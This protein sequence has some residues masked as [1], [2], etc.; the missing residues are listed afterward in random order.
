M[1]NLWKQPTE[2]PDPLRG[3]LM[4][5]SGQQCRWT[6]YGWSVSAYDV[7]Y[8]E[9][10]WCYWDEFISEWFYREDEINNLNNALEDALNVLQGIAAAMIAFGH[11]GAGEGTFEDIERIKLK[12]EGTY[13]KGK[14]L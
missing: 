4:L 1:Q 6:A 7:H 2:K 5:K 12:K 10:E 3:D 8:V 9:E 13:E 14:N 11:N